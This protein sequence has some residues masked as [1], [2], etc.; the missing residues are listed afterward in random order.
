MVLADVI[1]ARVAATKRRLLVGGMLQSIEWRQKTGPRDVRGRQ[2]VSTTMIDAFVEQRPAL[3][4]KRLTTER[5]DDTVLTILDALAI[6]DSDTFRWG[7]DT[8][9]V[10]KID[11][12]LQD[13]DSGV[14]F[15][16]EVTVVRTLPPTPRLTFE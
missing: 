8:Y 14:R 16:S 7:G 5:A 13:E 6:T 12:L 10:T 11:G 3:D 15:S 1:T 2:S 4:Y 9:S